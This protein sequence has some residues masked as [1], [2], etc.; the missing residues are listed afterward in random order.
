MYAFFL[1]CKSMQFV[2]S[3]FTENDTRVHR[4]YLFHMT[5]CALCKIQMLQGNATILE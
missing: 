5:L 4:I 2:D 1:Y 3:Y